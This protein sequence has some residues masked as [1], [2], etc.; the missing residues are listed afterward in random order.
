MKKRKAMHDG[1]DVLQKREMMCSNY[2]LWYEREERDDVDVAF[3]MGFVAVMDCC[4]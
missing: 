1:H 3:C 4:R 2:L